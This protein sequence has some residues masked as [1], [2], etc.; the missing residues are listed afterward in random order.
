MSFYP[1]KISEKFYNPKHA[2]TMQNPDAKGTGASFICGAAVRF[3]L[4]IDLQNKQILEAKYKTNGCGFAV[5]TT[6]FLAENVI[7]KKLTE[8][9]GLESWENEFDKSRKHCA[10]IALDALQNAL[11]DFR[12]SQ[13]E[14]FQ[15]EKA[16]ICTC[17]GVSEEIIETVI[18]TNQ[19]ETVEEVGDLCNAGTGCGS[20]RFLIQEL[21]DDY[22]SLEK[23]FF[24]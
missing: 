20:C 1:P 18:T 14:E 19:A 22:E 3:F 21:I 9:H 8:L 15:G 7:N 4:K 24:D 2:G 16:L 13:I 11:A 10:K 23:N 12:L 17:F 5:A 6:E